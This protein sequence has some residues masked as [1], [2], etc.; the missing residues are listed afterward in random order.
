M[1]NTYEDAY[2]N[3]NR[4]RTKFGSEADVRSAWIKELENKLGV[5]FSLEQKY[6]DARYNQTIIEFKAYKSFHQKTTSQ[7][8]KEAIYERLEKYIP[9]RS[10]E[11]GIPQS[12]YI[13][14]AID[15]ESIAIAYFPEG[16]SKIVHGP[17]LKLSLASV[18]LVFDIC[19]RSKRRAI[20]AENLI[21]D[22]GHMSDIGIETMQT[23]WNT[24]TVFLEKPDNNKVKMLFQE[25]K[26]LYGQVAD[27]S[28]YQEKAI[29]NSLG[30]QCETSSPERLSMILFV[31]HT[32]DS[33]LIKL[34]AA[35]IVSQA[36]KLTSYEDFAQHAL[37]LSD[38]E[39]IQTMEADIEQGNLYS[40][41][42]IY[43]FVEEVLFSWYIDAYH[44]GINTVELANSF[45][46]VFI[47]L[48]TYKPEDLE[49]ARTNDVLKRFYQNIVPDVLR[50]SL[51]E[52]YT[53]D[54]LVE[55]TLD[56]V[57]GKF[58]SH[59][60]L[61][62]T[63]G[64]ASF[65]IA[66]IKRIRAEQPDWSSERLL[67]YITENVWG[68][69]LNPLAVQTARVNYLIAIADLIKANPGTPIEIPVLLADAVY[70]PA[71]DPDQEDS[72]VSYTIGSNTANLT[73]TIP[74]KL[75]LDRQRLDMVFE[76]MGEY[77]N[78]NHEFQA[79][80]SELHQKGILSSD[81]AEK[82]GPCL[83][84][85]YDR[86][87]A[88]HNNRWN[89]IWF[90]IAKN[91]FWSATTGE[92]DVIVGN[93]PWVRWSKLP[94]LYRE[95]V[96]PTCMQYDIFSSTPYHGGN[97]LDIS[98]MITYTVADKWLEE[99]GQLVFL[100]TQTH[101]QSASSEGFRK[102]NIRDGLY[103]CP[104][105][106]DDL[107][108]LKPFPDAANSTSIFSAQKSRKKPSYPVPYQ[109]W[110]T[111]D[112]VSNTIPEHAKKED[113]LRDIIK[114]DWE[115]TPVGNE[116]APWSVLPRG[117]YQHYDK[118]RGRSTWIAG[119]KGIT[120]DLNGIYFVKVL[121]VGKNGQTIQIQT[122]PSAGKT[123]IGPSQKFWIEP[124]LLYPLMKGAGDIKPCRFNPKET[125]YAIV[126]N[127]GITKSAYSDAIDAVEHRSPQLYRYFC[128]YE[129]ALRNRSTYRTRMKDAPFYA[130]YNVGEYTF[131]PWK[132]VWAEQPGNK[133]FPSAV[134]SNTDL[135]GI[136][137]KTIIPDHKIY[138]VDFQQE[139]PAYY[140][141]GLLQC[142]SVQVFLKSHLLKLQVGNIFKH[143]SL[144]EY[145][146][147]NEK[148]STLVELTKTA[149]FCDEAEYSK[150]LEKIA[151]LGDVI[152][153]EWK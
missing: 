146:E 127:H 118:L 147:K 94:E 112:G 110:H 27:L 23:L 90:R 114:D 18:S 38:D 1:Y 49:I 45:R 88:L 125:L 132:L 140:L 12:E 149:H 103:L 142:E 104:I 30:F 2:Q 97:E 25:W 77:V 11:E 9:E 72:L 46:Q 150:L 31:I 40:R 52:F 64:S 124:E 89:G 105:S 76:I 119:R 128:Q 48:S 60:F 32:Y 65:L 63:C 37:N 79:A 21:S 87:L 41:A 120:C 111:K 54:W 6:V 71:P 39:L 99:D 73:I 19:K 144:P 5:K 74:S 91:Y 69:D 15:G 33:I 17:I 53:P 100:I 145:D 68:F 47:G 80:L 113:V 36:V 121:Q 59:R 130:I 131:A 70:F 133:Y 135:P 92:F 139:A 26:A 106:V 122:R 81:E 34:I 14:I 141:C 42:N 137:R 151:V 61:D 67:K 107:K 66:I 83:K 85:T 57:N 13:G 108:E 129:G 29:N 35:E 101:F 123:N 86:V 95:R 44:E 50:K 7:K 43:G 96:K 16:S 82:W 109:I 56:K 78:N 143:M 24:L 55:V 28:E 22:F 51:G 20:T 117:T 136:G 148:H 126:P 10:K 75:A 93:P 102:F 98:G 152:L 134:V 4:A 84:G 3:L 8:F 116:C 58:T 115:A 153:S 62:P 138:F